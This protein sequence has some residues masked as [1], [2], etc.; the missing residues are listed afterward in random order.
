MTDEKKVYSFKDVDGAITTGR[1]GSDSLRTW[2]CADAS[3]GH[4]RAR[5]NTGMR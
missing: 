3:R 1:D 5:H 4:Q 2:E